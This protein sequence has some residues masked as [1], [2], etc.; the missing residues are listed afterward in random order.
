M[1]T[2]KKTTKKTTKTTVVEAPDLMAWACPECG[3]THQKHGNG[4]K[5]DCRDRGGGPCN[6]LVCECWEIG[7]NETISNKPDHGRSFAN[8]CGNAMCYHCGWSGALPPRPKGLAPW[9]K[10]ALDAGWTMP[11]KRKKELGL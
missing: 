11:A 1:T 3:A 4:G 9:E 7:T 2:K 10:K 5:D 6:G 8:V